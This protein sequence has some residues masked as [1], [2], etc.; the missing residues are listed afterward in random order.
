MDHVPL[1]DWCTPHTVSIRPLT[2]HGANGPIYGGATSVAAW[3]E[4]ERTLVRDANGDEVVSGSA[5]YVNVDVVA[6]PGSL[7]TVWPGTPGAR[8]A[9]VITSERHHHPAL[10]SYQILRLE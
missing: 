3:A 10:P 4:D 9:R 8:E 1:P 7:V 6:P 5:V 2:G